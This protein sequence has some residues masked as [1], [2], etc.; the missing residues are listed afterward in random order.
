MNLVSLGNSL[1][2]RF[3]MDRKT[4]PL[5]PRCG[6]VSADVSLCPRMCARPQQSWPLRVCWVKAQML[7]AVQRTQ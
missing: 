4:P 1:S 7:A 2:E 6:P 3:P 5:L